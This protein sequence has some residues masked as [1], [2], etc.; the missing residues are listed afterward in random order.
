MF[1]YVHLYLFHVL[2]VFYIECQLNAIANV[3][4]MSVPSWSLIHHK[5]TLEFCTS[6][7]YFITSSVPV[8]R[9]CSCDLLHI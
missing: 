9:C 8:I 3:I 6:I 1:R 4:A 7:F 5:N 2:A